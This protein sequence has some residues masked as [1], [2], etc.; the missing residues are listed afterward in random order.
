MA[1]RLLSDLAPGVR[2]AA[3]L[4]VD[5]CGKDG[6]RVLIYCTLRSNHEQ[7]LLYASGRTVPGQILTNARPGESL[8]NADAA[9]HAWAFD[10]VPLMPD[11]APAWGAVSSIERM[12]ACG[13]AA[14]LEWAGRWR[15]SLRERVHFQIQR[16]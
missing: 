10:A 11:G 5:L 9:G 12:G 7:A 15:G 16:G 6:L 13:E 8:H 4:F 3:V 1:S 14:G 2:S